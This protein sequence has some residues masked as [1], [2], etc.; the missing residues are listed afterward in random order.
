MS[1]VLKEMCVTEKATILASTANQYLFEVY[2]NAN[3]IEIAKAVESTFK[4]T[5]TRVNTLKYKGKVKRS[6]LS[7]GKKGKTS[8]GK[9]AIVTLSEGEKIELI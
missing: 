9:R 4:V 7:K 5:V 3:K 1:N 2:P 8:G 6:R